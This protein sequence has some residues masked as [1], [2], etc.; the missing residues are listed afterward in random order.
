MAEELAF[1][2]AG[3]DR[4]A[5]HLHEGAVLSTAHVVDGTRHEFLAGPRLPKDEDGRVGRRDRPRLLQDLLKGFASA[6]DLPEAPLGPDLFFQVDLLLG[7]PV[8]EEGQLLEVEGVVHGR[9]HD[10]GDELEEAEVHSVI[11]AYLPRRRDQHSQ[12]SLR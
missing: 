9:G 11:D 8:L 7:E 3:G 10:R 2:E 1:E 5:V 4:R 6:H 12:V